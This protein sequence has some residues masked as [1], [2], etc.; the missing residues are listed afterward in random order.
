[1][2]GKPNYFR[3]GLFVLA[4]L[5]L[6]FVL[7][8]VLGGRALF[9]PRT[10]I[11]TYFNESVAGLGVGAPVQFRGVRVGEVSEILLSSVYQADIP[12]DSRAN[13]IVVRMRI[14]NLTRA[15]LERDYKIYVE[16]GLRAQTQLAG[17][18]GQQFIGLD[19]LDPAR[20][21]PLA[22]TWT[23]KHPYLP[24]APSLSNQIIANAQSFLASLD[25]ADIA[26]LGQNL[27]RL[28]LTLDRRLSEIPLQKIGVEL[29]ATLAASR[30]AMERID[31]TL[32]AAKLDASFARV[33]KILADPAFDSAPQDLAVV[34]AR[35]RKLAESGELERAVAGV[36]QVLAR[37]NR[38][39][40]DNEEPLRAAL[41]DLRDTL[42]NLRM[43]T[44][45]VKRWPPGL[46]FSAPPKSVELP[47]RPA[48]EAK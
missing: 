2:A 39:L 40:A 1:M 21:P 3:L 20:N 29:V 4:S 34:A 10:T 9:T 8:F 36:D 47:V 48:G 32:A 11:E 45:T 37:S 26:Q 12:L 18:T 25:Q 13:Y 22:F 42:L 35:L 27:N 6:G 24:S 33:N 38:L 16:R 44:D 14:D 15:E 46:L 5:T 17:V 19:F 28:V 7:L 31:R 30:S 43:L 23:P 41:S